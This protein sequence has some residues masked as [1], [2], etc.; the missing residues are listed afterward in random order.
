MVTTTRKNKKVS[1]TQIKKKGERNDTQLKKEKS[2]RK[3]EKADTKGILD[4]INLSL[5]RTCGI[6]RPFEEV[7]KNLRKIT[8][9]E[10]R[11]K[12]IECR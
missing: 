10:K 8:R 12:R 7:T 5:R 9:R 1:L 6:Y 2:L 4:P 3:P 11:E